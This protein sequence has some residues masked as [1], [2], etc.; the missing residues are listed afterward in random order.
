MK[1]Q[2]AAAAEGAPATDT[3]QEPAWRRLSPR[4]LAVHPLHEA[5]RFLPVVLGVFF[6]GRSGEKP[7]GLIGLALAV[8]IGLGRYF[9]TTYR[10]TD[11][12]VQ[13]RRGLLRR[14]VLS[15]PRD[16][17]RSVDVSA[18]VLQRA[19]GLRRLAIGTGRSDRH[20]D[21]LV[22]DALDTAA[23][24]LLRNELLHHIGQ[25]ARADA[26]Q[27]D[28]TRDTGAEVPH[29]RPAGDGRPRRARYVKPRSSGREQRRKESADEI[30]EDADRAGEELIATLQP[31]WARFGAFTLSGL[32]SAGVLLTSAVTFLNS[33]ELGPDRF[34]PVRALVRQLS[35]LP[36]PLAVL[37]TVVLGLLVVSLLSIIGYVVSFWNFRLTRLGNGTLKLTRGL[38]TTR[39]VTIEGRRL[40]GV[41]ISETLPLRLVRGARCIA[42][43]TGLRTERG[44]E[45]GGSL[46]LPPAPR[47]RAREVGAAVYGD[48]APMDC[49]LTRHGDGARR[50]RLTRA[51]TTAVVAVTLIGA[52]SLWAGWPVWSC[53]AS[54]V[55]LPLGELVG[56]DRYHSL[57]HALLDGAHLVTRQG[58][59]V[60]RRQVLSCDAAVGWVFHQSFFQ[61]RSGVTTL[62][63]ATAAGRQYYNVLDLP[64]Q[65]ATALAAA[66]RPDWL[67][68]FLV[69]EN[70][71]DGG[72]APVRSGPA[73]RQGASDGSA[74]ERP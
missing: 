17:I 61:R 29:P 2:T 18:R 47:A 71:T 5:L 70:D 21:G 38:T 14:E 72:A 12:H 43:T 1:A 41:E 65:E 66:A 45:H 69:S 20:G 19:L 44:A 56:R 63:V 13:V 37:E 53:L 40:R 68:P 11:V 57:G 15:V 36:M 62:T 58:S 31:T 35:S 34:P 33:A 42:I 51:R 4:M 6:L 49:P 46:L 8:V 54:L 55:L 26:P 7:W 9:T 74:P 67:E 10:V 22:L 16:R 52:L 3:E 28:A 27:A 59:L 60:R 32:A 48:P 25:P 64:T 23:A 30:R 73:R 24:E 39:S 50:R